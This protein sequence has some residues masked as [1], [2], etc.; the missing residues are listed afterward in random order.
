MLVGPASE[1]LSG[2]LSSQWLLSGERSFNPGSVGGPG[3]GEPTNLLP[4]TGGVPYVQHET[5]RRRP[6]WH[7]HSV[8]G[9][10]GGGGSL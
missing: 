9:S 2:P 6:H 8:S 4:T 1:D 3:S 10:G 7:Y 5:L